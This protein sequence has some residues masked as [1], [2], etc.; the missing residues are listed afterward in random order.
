M[1]TRILEGNNKIADCSLQ[2]RISELD[3]HRY[4]SA[5]TMADLGGRTAQ[6]GHRGQN[7]VC[8]F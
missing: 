7:E 1:N 8:F 4:G 3:R 2:A 6:E 5:I